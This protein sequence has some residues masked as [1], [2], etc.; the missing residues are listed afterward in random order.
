MVDSGARSRSRRVPGARYV[1]A[2]MAATLAAAALLGLPAGASA[3]KMHPCSADTSFGC[4]SLRVPVDHSGATPGSLS[5]AVAAQRSYPKNAGVMVALSGGPGQNSVGAVSSWAL[6]LEPV[7]RRYRLVVLDQ[8]GTGLSGPLRCPELQ[9]VGGLDEFTPAAVRRCALRTGPRRAFHRTTDTVDDLESLR[10]ALGVKKIGL[11]GIS[12]GTWVAQEY[13]RRY[14]KHTDSLILDS[15]VG[16]EPQDAFSIDSF[17]RLPRVFNELCARGRCKGATPDFT[18]DIGQVAAKLRQGPVRGR[19]FDVVGGARTTSYT[20]ESQLFFLVTSGDLNPF[21]QARMPGAINAAAKGDVEPLLR[22]KKVGQGPTSK[23]GEFSWGLTTTTTCLDSQLPYSLSSDPSTRPA[24]VQSALAAVPP[25]AYAP[26]SADTVRDTSAADDCLLW[27]RD[28]RPRPSAGGLPD[29]PSLLLSG[30]LDM[31][32]PL[33]DALRV[34]AL[35]PRSELV[36]VPGN[37][38]DQVDSDGTG[39]VAKAL[40]RFTARKP[41]GQPCRNTSNLVP[42][43][44]RAPRSLSELPAP[45]RIPGDR[46]RTLLAALRSVEDARFSALEAVYAGFSPR[47][48]GL[49]GGSFAAT[50]AFEGALKLRNYSYVPGVRISGTVEVDGRKVTGRIRVDGPVSGSLTLRST[51]AASGRLGGRRVAFAA[52]KQRARSATDAGD[53]GAFP[54]IPAALLDPAT[55]RA[56]R[57]AAQR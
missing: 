38:H 55:L 33:E 52:A 6:S 42:P 28:D 21:M 35:L 46:G 3:L 2:V 19:I 44:S 49:R 13:A 57:S 54:A 47:G 12:Y 45:S 56:R 11:M 41:V 4:A 48:G 22:L 53:A 23:V 40:T 43:I 5:L 10:K 25:A 34:K 14:P 9:R 29:V 37:G 36:T 31:R 27:P 24:L 26:W 18:A 16:P 15:I 51:K 7:L 1:R 30:R 20:A 17:R 32:T 39:C 8:R 50:D